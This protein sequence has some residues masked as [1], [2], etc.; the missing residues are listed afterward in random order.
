MPESFGL[1]DRNKVKEVQERLTEALKNL[2]ERVS[3][4]IENTV[5]NAA[6]L[7]VE[8]YVSDDL[9]NVKWENGTFTNADRRVLSR[10]GFGGDTRTVLDAVPRDGDTELIDLHN[11]MVDRASQQRQ[12]LQKMLVS[13]AMELVNLGK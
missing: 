5:D 4:A 11:K 2:T 13:V 9:N 7:T 12:E 10:I 8:T 1:F 3:T 6:N